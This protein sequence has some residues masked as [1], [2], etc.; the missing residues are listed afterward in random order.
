MGVLLE[1]LTTYVLVNWFSQKAC[2]T[3][4]NV[5]KQGINAG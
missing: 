2:H 5:G 3:F 4:I 1:D